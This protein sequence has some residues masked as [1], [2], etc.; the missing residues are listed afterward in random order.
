M[1]E[2]IIDGILAALNGEFEGCTL[3][4]EEVKQGMKEPC[5]F[6]SCI[7]PN[8]KVLRGRRY[9]HTNQFAV[10]Y[11]TNAAE[12]RADCNRVSEQLFNCLELITVDG[13]LMR[14]TGME[15]VIEDDA[16]TFVVNYDYFSYRQNDIPAME[17]KGTETNLKG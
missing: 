4:T 16:L 1:I 13:E 7:S 12:P 14:G 5:F 10:Q 9:Q 8:T 17:E 3:Y 6:V 15:A 11:L 2:K